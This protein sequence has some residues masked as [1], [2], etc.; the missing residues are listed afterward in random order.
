MILL[1]STVKSLEIVL[2]SGSSS[3]LPVSSNW[4]DVNISTS[5]VVDYNSQLTFSN[6][7]TAVTVVP[8]PTSGITRQ[9]K[10]FNVSNP[11]VAAIEIIIQLNNNG[12][13]R[14]ILS[15]LLSQYESVQYLDGRGVI[16][17]TANGEQ[18]ESL[19]LINLT[20]Q[21]T[22]I[23]PV[24][25]GGT[26]DATLAAHGV[27]I[28]EG[29]SPIAVTSAG[30]SGQ[31][32]TS[33]GASAD[34]TFQTPS[35]GTIDNG[36]N[37]FRLSLTSGI[38]YTPTDVVGATTIYCVPYKGNRIALY[39]GANWNIR[40][41]AQ[42]S[43]ALGT[44]TSGKNYDVF[45][46]DNS[47]TPTLEFLVW[48]SDSARATAVVQQDGV[49][50]K[51][52]IPTRRLL[53]TFYTTSTT[54]TENSILNRVLDNVDNELECEFLVTLLN[55]WTYNIAT[56]RQVNGDASKRVNFVR[57]IQEGIVKAETQVTAG[58][59]AASINIVSGVGLDTTTAF[60]GQAGGIQ[61]QSANNPMQFGGKY[62]GSPAAGYHYLSW[63]EYVSVAGGNTTF[64]G[65]GTITNSTSCMYGSLFC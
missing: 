20:S 54:T 45:C 29:T 64:Y 19:L 43:L 5:S 53:G 15:V 34:P 11:N 47:G 14:I 36:I 13:E 7:L 33:N 44:L 23:L 28:G 3:P 8:S 55:T 58:N 22:G 4:I 12:T 50:V 1:D 56:I 30:T 24:V 37:D 16:V 31:V 32:L 60:S 49:W 40:T 51:S 10:E 59:G 61:T 65:T 42:F 57:S 41:S 27:L 25:N 17:L 18:K 2:G 48:T 38:Y 35:G 52:G 39:D 46:Y 21:V 6:N 26:G 63:N 62:K 9:V